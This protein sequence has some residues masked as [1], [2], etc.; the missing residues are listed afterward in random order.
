MPIVTLVLITR[1]CFCIHD[2]SHVLY[3]F[4]FIL[5]RHGLA[6]VI[7]HTIPYLLTELEGTELGL[8]FQSTWM[9]CK[10]CVITV[11]FVSATLSLGFCL[12]FYTVL[13]P[14]IRFH[15]PLNRMVW[16]RFL[17]TSSCLWCTSWQLAWVPRCPGGQWEEWDST[18]FW[19]RWDQRATII[20]YLH[21]SRTGNGRSRSL[22]SETQSQYWDCKKKGNVNASLGLEPSAFWYR[23]ARLCCSVAFV[24]TANTLF[25][26]DLSSFFF[27]FQCRWHSCLL[28]TINK[29]MLLVQSVPRFCRK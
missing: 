5:I 24:C 16:R 3:I 12:H 27:L 2:F 18:M 29:G 22:T 15:C 17:P 25:N 28:Y 1:R 14:F 7:P 26:C 9:L 19:V 20:F 10:R 11:S 4:L 21:S 8:V 6:N 23:I 13:P